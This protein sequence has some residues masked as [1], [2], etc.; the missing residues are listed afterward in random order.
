MHIP[1]NWDLRCLLHPKPIAPH[2]NICHAGEYG[3]GKREVS[4]DLNYFFIPCRCNTGERA[5]VTSNSDGALATMT[6]CAR[7]ALSS[8]QAFRRTL[9]MLSKW[10]A[11]DQSSVQV[12]S[13]QRKQSDSV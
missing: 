3:W 9:V 5:I 10:C 11:L 4:C 13:L 7:E 12:P 8:S 1:D 6:T 2:R